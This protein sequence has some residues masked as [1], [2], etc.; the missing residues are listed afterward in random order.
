[1]GSWGYALYSNDVA[2]DLRTAM[3][4]LSL[5]PF[6]ETKLFDCIVA[7]EPDVSKNPEHED[8]TTFWLVVADQL[9]KKRI[10]NLR[11]MEIAL[12]IIE[13]GKDLRN[14]KQLGA[15]TTG[16][17]KRSKVLS[18]LGVRLNA[19]PKEFK[20]RVVD[21]KP[22]EF[23]L[24]LGNVY[25]YPTCNGAPINPYLSAQNL[26]G[27]KL[28]PNGIGLL[29]VTNRG[30]AFEYFAWY[31]VC[32]VIVPLDRLPEEETLL[33]KLKWQYA[34]NGCCSNQHFRKIKLECIAHFKPLVDN[35]DTY[36]PQ[37][38]DGDQTAIADISI[39]NCMTIYPEQVRH[40][41]VEKSGRVRAAVI[42][43]PPT[44]HQLCELSKLNPFQKLI[45]NI[46]RKRPKLRS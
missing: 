15:S 45:P 41:S 22:E 38:V 11:A 14:F 46:L 10:F 18:T 32:T 13:S 6:D 7:L 4:K 30:R 42:P 21:S 24:D 43:E 27:Q 12:G 44:I 2:A 35:L 25:A 3:T 8:Y 9:A 37:R 23:L 34:G 39:A 36:F 29:L 33:K 28:Q 19:Q 16:L 5:L 17:Q 26:N 20:S 31:Q 1:M 40:V